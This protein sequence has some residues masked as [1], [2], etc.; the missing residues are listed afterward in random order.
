M[1]MDVIRLLQLPGLR[2]DQHKLVE[3]VKALQIE[4]HS[5]HGVECLG[6]LFGGG[7]ELLRHD[8][9]TL[10]Y[11]KDRGR[12]L[13]K[14]AMSLHVL[15]QAYGDAVTYGFHLFSRA[16]SKRLIWLAGLCNFGRGSAWR[17]FRV[18]MALPS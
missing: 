11:W 13:S 6:V 5:D 17:P 15:V 8:V 4:V 14:C 18:E 1:S 2:T 3:I 10:R 7:N 9:R 16:D 12:L